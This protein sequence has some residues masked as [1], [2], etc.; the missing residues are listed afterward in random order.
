M[1]KP[2]LLAFA[3]VAMPALAFDQ[4]Q[5]MQPAALSN[6]QSVHVVPVALALPAT[7]RR[8]GARGDEPRPVAARDAEAKAAELTTALRRGSPRTSRSSMPR[9]PACSSSKPP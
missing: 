8:V 2:L 9:A 7:T 1:R 5:V 4:A 3:L 6:V